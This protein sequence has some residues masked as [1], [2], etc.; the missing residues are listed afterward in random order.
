MNDQ[1]REK[2]LSIKPE[3]LYFADYS[4]DNRGNKI[5]GSVVLKGE[6]LTENQIAT[7]EPVE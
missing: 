7:C 5:M 4:I 1:L 2:V 3:K 6:D